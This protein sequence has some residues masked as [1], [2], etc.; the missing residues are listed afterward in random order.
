MG[1]PTDA[2]TKATV[3]AK[4]RDEGMTAGDAGNKYGVTTK[5]IYRWLREGVEASTDSRNLILENNRL[6][7]E[8]EQA[9]R[10]L[11]RLTAETQ[12]SKD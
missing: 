3:L 10:I 1:K 7:K 5:T 12:R 8:L 6:K 4:I 2:H 9:Y 11:G